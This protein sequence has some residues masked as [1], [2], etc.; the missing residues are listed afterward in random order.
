[1]TNEAKRNEDTV[2]PLVR[3]RYPSAASRLAD[4]VE[5][6]EELIAN[7]VHYCVEAV[8]DARHDLAVLQAARLYEPNNRMRKDK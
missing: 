2:E 6:L 4:I 1:M 5:L 7:E 8:A 3:L